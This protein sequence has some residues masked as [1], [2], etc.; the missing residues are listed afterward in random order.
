MGEQ[1][2]IAASVVLMILTPFLGRAA[3]AIE[4]R[5]TVHDPE[6]TRER[7]DEERLQIEN[8]VII[9]G[10][11]SAARDLARGLRSSGVPFVILTLGPAGA[12]QAEVEGLSVLRGDYSRAHLLE[13]AGIGAARVLAIPDDE[14]AMA[15]R[16]ASVARSL[17]PGIT[18]VVRTRH[19]GEIDSILHE[20][21]DEVVVDEIETS[22]RMIS[23]V[24]ARYDRADV[25]TVRLSGSQRSS[26]G[27]DHV[28]R[29]APQVST[30]ARGC[31][32]CLAIGDTWVHLRI[33]MTCGNV[34]CCDSSKNTHATRHHNSSGHP[35]IRSYQEGEEWAWCY[36]DRLTL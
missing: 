31:A 15:R 5:Q 11:G 20:G 33:C 9:A 14:P 10:Y 4:P 19:R 3:R 22:V 28:R 24:L 2:F 1:M 18:I 12:T 23:G 17:N 25:R 8:H 26:P 21:A 36:P 16:V 13:L 29:V 32:E 6:E 30:A 35:I 7:P 27:C 34:G